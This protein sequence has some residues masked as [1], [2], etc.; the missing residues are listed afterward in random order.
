MAAGRASGV[1]VSVSAATQEQL[2]RKLPIHVG[3]IVETLTV[4]DWVKW[5]TAIKK[6]DSATPAN[7]QTAHLLPVTASDLREVKP[8]LGFEPAWTKP[9]KLEADKPLSSDT[10]NQLTKTVT[11]VKPALA[12]TFGPAIVRTLPALSPEIKLYQD[13]RVERAPGE[14][15]MLIIIRPA[16]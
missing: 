6:L 1:A 8:L 3:L 4:E 13:R 2:K 11:K 5:L 12:F 10:I 9:V 7:S 14:L 15:P 16:N